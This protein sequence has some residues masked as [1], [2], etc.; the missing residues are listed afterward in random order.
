MKSTRYIAPG[1]FDGKPGEWL[2]RERERQ[3]ILGIERVQIFSLKCGRN[4]REDVMEDRG[5][6]VRHVAAP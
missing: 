3:Q 1:D 4:P 2:A 5:I 6:L